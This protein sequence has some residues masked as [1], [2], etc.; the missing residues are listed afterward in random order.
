MKYLLLAYTPADAWDSATAGE[1]SDAALAAFAEYERFT[2]ELM[3]S[4]ELV[5]TEGLGHP[6]V[7]VTVRPSTGGAVVTDGPFAEYKE[8]LASFAV[9]DVASQERAV[10]IVGRIVEALGESVEVR[11]IMGEEFA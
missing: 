8:V 11:P 3:A 1:P 7:S 4:G 10:E 9:V 5:V 6:S 2:R